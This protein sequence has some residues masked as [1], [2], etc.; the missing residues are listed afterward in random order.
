MLVDDRIRQCSGWRRFVWL[1]LADRRY[2]GAALRRRAFAGRTVHSPPARASHAVGVE[3][4]ENGSYRPGCSCG[5]S[6]TVYPSDDPHTA[7]MAAEDDC[8]EHALE[9][10]DGWIVVP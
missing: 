3:R 8:I 1:A 2:R 5:W 10:G 7:P 4:L 9:V 6:T